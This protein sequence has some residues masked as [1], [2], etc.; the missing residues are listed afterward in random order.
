LSASAQEHPEAEEE[1]L[2][3]QQ[4][5]NLKLHLASFGYPD[6]GNLRSSKKKDVRLRLK[7]IHALLKQRQKDADYRA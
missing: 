3:T 1:D 5:N 4:C 7:V 6:V 2:L